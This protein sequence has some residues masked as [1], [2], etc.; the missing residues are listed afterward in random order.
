[1]KTKIYSYFLVLIQAIIILLLLFLNESI[2]TNTISIFVFF[3]ALL[4]GFYTLSFNKLFNFNI[5]PLIKKDAM[6]ITS[7]AYKYIRHPMYFSVFLMMF[8]IILLDIN[9]INIFL[10]TSLLLVLYLKAKKEESL[11]SKES[12]KYKE[13]MKKT[14]MFIPFIL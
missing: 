10:Y 7:G 14:K 3:L 12:V 9:M 13:Y 6:L 2:F 5:S 11:W 4:F 1:M 8:S